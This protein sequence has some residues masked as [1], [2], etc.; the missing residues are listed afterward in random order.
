[1]R[2]LPKVQDGE[3]QDG[4]RNMCFM[5]KLNG[6]SPTSSKTI[7]LLVLEWDAHFNNMTMEPKNI[8]GW[9]DENLRAQIWV[10]AKDRSLLHS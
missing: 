9:L 2:G 1:M 3:V 10:N 4:G 5:S 8:V 7:R 6:F